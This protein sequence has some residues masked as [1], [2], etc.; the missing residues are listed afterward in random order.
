MLMLDLDELGT[1]F[2]G[3]W[4]WSTGKPNIAWFDRRDHFGDPG[5]DLAE[6]IRDLVTSRTG[7]RP[8]GP[9]RLLTHL[10]YF[11]HCFNPVS[12]Y[13]CYGRDNTTLEAIV[14]EVN[15]TPWGEQF[16]YVLPCDAGSG[17]RTQKFQLRKHFHVSPFMPMDIDYQWHF[18]EPGERLQVFMRNIHRGRVMFDAT[19]AFK[20]Q[21]ASGWNL[22]M[23]LFRHPLVT[24]KVVAAIHLQA[25]KLWL[26]G[27]PFYTHP[28][29]TP[30]KT[31]GL[32]TPTRL[33]QKGSNYES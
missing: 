31:Q 2:K 22:A 28:S 1:V 3:R 4:F 12:F 18:S 19:L 10:R 20:R 14:A 16:M 30:S 15:N 26:K 13:F 21:P 24:L 27:A 5:T 6:C 29:K 25:L 17:A 8:G 9:V 11:G 23:S 32:R 33:G 7:R